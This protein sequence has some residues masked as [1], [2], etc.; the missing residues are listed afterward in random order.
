M[1]YEP[2]T[3]SQTTGRVLVVDDDRHVCRAL[4]GL[5][6]CLGYETDT[7][8][9]E[10]ACLERMNDREYSCVLLDIHLARGESGL[11]L[12]ARIAEHRPDIP[13]II[14]TG[15]PDRNTVI[16]AI[17]AG[18]YDFVCKPVTKD[19]LEHV[20]ARAVVHQE[21]MHRITRLQLELSNMTPSVRLVGVSAPMR[22]V[23]DR[24]RRVSATDVA[25]LVLGESGTGKELVAREIHARSRRAAGPFVAINCAAMPAT[26]LES[27]LFGH[28]R[29]AFTD[30][31]R[32]HRGVFVQACG[33]TLFLDEI[34][35]MPTDLQVKLLR[36]LQDRRVRPLG[37]DQDIAI[38]T[39]IIA[40]TNTDI[41]ADVDS[42]KFRRDLFYRID[43]VRIDLPPL[44]AR[45]ADILSLAHHFLG[46][47][48][49]A[50]EGGAL[51][52]T[53]EAERAL[54]DYSWPGNVRELENAIAHAVALM[55]SNEI[56]PADL[57]ATI[58]T[59]RCKR[60]VIDDRD[61]DKLPTLDEFTERYINRVLEAVNGNKSR[62][63]RVLGIDRRT[64][65]RKLEYFEAARSP[66]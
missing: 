28:T 11:A 42:G 1:S 31:K 41:E 18:A 37:G 66:P 7:A 22:G 6:G 30:A 26:L 51:G 44:R 2:F 5:L 65:Y 50:A 57:P 47:T 9:T 14:M 62:A 15:Q 13:A 43:V 20:I 63:S 48:R 54:M 4:A 8:M 64:L 40:A 3:E 29:G 10:A 53:S 32:P 21:S 49:R 34:G 24:I 59:Y 55:R 38:D 12:C 45:G 61:L 46:R 35:D 16:G 52:I 25:V 60:I 56:E 36:V 33:G 23:H 39:R 17:R 19:T 27:E 58:T